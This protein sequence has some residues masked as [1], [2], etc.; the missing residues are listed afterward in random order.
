[1]IFRAHQT[2][3]IHTIMVTI[4]ALPIKKRLTEITVIPAMEAIYRLQVC[5][6]KT[7]KL[8]N[9]QTHHVDKTQV[10]VRFSRVIFW[11]VLRID[12]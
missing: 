4:A 2:I 8:S 12:R 9:V 6:A 5:A 11:E 7:T 1:M 3:R 10:M